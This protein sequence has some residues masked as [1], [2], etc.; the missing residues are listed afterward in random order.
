MYEQIDAYVR[1]LIER[2]TPQRTVWNVERLRQGKPADWNYIDGCMLTALL[3]MSEITGDSRYFD[4]TERFL[5]SFIAPDGTIPTY[6]G[7]KYSLDDINEGRVLFPLYEATGKEKYRKAAEILRGQLERQP[8][9]WEGNFWHKAIYPNQVWLDG[10]YMAQ[11]F[12]ALYEKRFGEGDYSDILRQIETVRARMFVE[13][14]RLY[15]HGYDASRTA[16]WANPETGRSRSFWLRSVGWFAVALADLLEILPAGRERTRLVEIFVEMIAGA[17]TYADSE[18]GMFWQVMN[19]G[20]R[21]GNYLE[22]SGSSMLAYAMLKGARLGV[23]PKEC[24][25]KG[26]RAFR[27]VTERYLSFENGGL[28]LGGICLVAGLGPENN[29]RRDGSYEYYVSEPVVEND[30]KGVAPFL[31]CYTEIKRLPV[32]A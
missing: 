1:E 6:D 12:S 24:A 27:G 16:F 30:A 26:E 8:R 25:A 21:A 19:Q 9:T 14:T 10:I 4:F 20:G 5:D 7:S 32:K 15:C 23:L 3:S 13:E 22:T 31:L 29:R 17:E 11:P 2:S 18:S 28:R